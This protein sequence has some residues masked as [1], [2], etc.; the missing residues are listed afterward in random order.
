MM[1]QL[2]PVLRA[3]V[4]DDAAAIVAI[5]NHYILNSTIS[6]E[7]ET[8]SE[9]QMQQRIADVQSKG[10]PWLVL[11]EAG[12]L[13]GYAYATPW[14]VRHAYRFSV[15]TSVYLDPAWHGRGLGRQLYTELLAQLSHHGCHLAI[16]GIALP[17][18]GSIALH[19]A[20]GF[21]QVACFNEVGYKFG[22]WL[23]VGYWQKTLSNQSQ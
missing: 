6:F 4:L 17:N 16:G 11:E 7:E 19:E 23:D 10:L 18:P 2:P 3:A 9:A 20:L 21:R 12:Q 8:V 22:R 13:L 15:E 14:R 1:S 5:Y